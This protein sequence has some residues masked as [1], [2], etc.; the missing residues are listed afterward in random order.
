MTSCGQWALYHMPTERYIRWFCGSAT[1]RRPECI[2]KFWS[3]RVR[4]ISALIDEYSLIRFFTLTLNRDNIPT[5]MNAWDYIH[6]PWSKLRKRL[7]RIANFKFVAI[8]EAHKNN[9]YPHIHGFTNIW[10]HQQKWSKLWS[11]CEGGEVVWIE[12][13]KEDGVSQYVSKS[14][15]VAKYVGKDNLARANKQKGKHRTLWRSTKLKA[16]FELTSSKD[17]VIIKRKVFNEDGTILDFFA[18]KGVWSDE[19]EDIQRKDLETTCSSI[20]E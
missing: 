13:V 5:G 16:K 14:L 3:A 7:N 9:K 18:K 1:C 8:L 4:L 20:L 11:E 6:S 15:E 12:K 10:L 19:Y 2:K 17:W